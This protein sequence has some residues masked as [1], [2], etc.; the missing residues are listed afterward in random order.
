MNLGSNRYKVDKNNRWS[1]SSHPRIEVLLLLFFVVVVGSSVKDH[2]LA[3]L[4]I[5]YRLRNKH[6]DGATIIATLHASR[7]STNDET[8]G[9]HWKFASG[10]DSK[11]C[12]NW[13]Y[14]L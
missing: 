9:R 5:N 2:L 4:F 12:A 10:K 3:N 1:D 6:R 14:I 13:I 11:C 7:R 8:L